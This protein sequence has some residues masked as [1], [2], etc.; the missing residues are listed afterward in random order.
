VVD[1]LEQENNDQI[2]QKLPVWLCAATSEHY[3]LALDWEPQ[4]DQVTPPRHE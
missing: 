1:S 3:V 2:E 4:P